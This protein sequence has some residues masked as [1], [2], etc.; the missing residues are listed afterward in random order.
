MTPLHSAIAPAIAIHNSTAADAPSSAAPDTASRRPEYA[1]KSNAPATRKVHKIEN[2]IFSHSLQIQE[3]NRVKIYK[4]FT[5]Q[6][7][8]KLFIKSFQFVIDKLLQT[9]ICF[10]HVP[11]TVARR[12]LT[13]ADDAGKRNGDG[14][15]NHNPPLYGAPHWKEI[16]REIHRNC[17]K[18]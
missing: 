3:E 18:S 15:F 2:A 11:E 12:G 17:K 1:P 6:N 8:Y 16:H 10:I 13:G 4:M 5:F 7:F 14:R 9:M